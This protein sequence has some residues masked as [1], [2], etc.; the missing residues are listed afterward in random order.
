M[1]SQ[2]FR[3]VHHEVFMIRS[4]RWQQRNRFLNTATNYLVMMMR[5]VCGRPDFNFTFFTGSKSPWVVCL[6]VC[7]FVLRDECRDGASVDLFLYWCFACKLYL[8]FMMSLPWSMV[9]LVQLSFCDG[10][11]AQTH[12]IFIDAFHDFSR[13]A[14]SRR[15]NWGPDWA[16]KIVSV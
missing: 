7:L 9:L 14:I 6:F 10:L 8:I 15:L 11:A 4:L 1:F 16:T 2:L 12:F 3:F 13:S 5:W